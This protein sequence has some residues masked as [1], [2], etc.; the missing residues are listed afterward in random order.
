M[1]TELSKRV[2]K[3]TLGLADGEVQNY[4]IHDNDGIMCLMVSKEQNFVVSKGYSGTAE[5]GLMLLDKLVQCA[6]SLEQAI[7]LDRWEQNHKN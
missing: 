6:K 4:T 1:E 3:V 2:V 7:S 5:T